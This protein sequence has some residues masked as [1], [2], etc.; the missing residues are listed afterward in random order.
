MYTA[1][2]YLT[3]PIGNNAFSYDERI[4]LWSVGKLCIPSLIS[5]TVDDLQQGSEICFEEVINNKL[6]SCTGLK[7]FVQIEYH[8]KQIFIVD[9]HNHALVFW[10]LIKKPLPVIHIDQHSDVKTNENIFPPGDD[11]EQFVNEKTNVGNF[12]SAAKNSWIISEV[13]QV[14]TDYALRELQASSI[15]HQ[16]FILDIDIDFRVDKE[17]TEDDRKIIQTLMKKAELVTV[18]TS[19]YFIDQEQA[20][21]IIRNILG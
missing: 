6:K 9:N 12:I 17:L 13:I 8:G 1:P 14:R 10:T 3:Q 5:W 4:A 11:I 16:A 7:H 21:S 2:S 15:M 19:P 18:A 20:I